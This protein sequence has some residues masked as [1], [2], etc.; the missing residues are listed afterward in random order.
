MAELEQL[1]GY[2]TAATIL[3]WGEPVLSGG[4]PD[5]HRVLL[6]GGVQVM[7]KPGQEEPWASVVRREAAGWQ[8]AKG[9]GFVG[10]VA[11]TGLRE[12][13]MRST[14][15][16]VVSSVQVT[17]PDGHGWCTSVDRLPPQEIWGAAV[18][19]AV[20]AHADHNINNWLGVPAPSD[21]CETHLRL[22]DTGNAFDIA[23]GSINST[24]YEHHHREHLPDELA[25]A[26]QRFVDNVP[27]ELAELLGEAE[28]ECVGHRA[29]QLAES[30]V[31]HIE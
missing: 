15:D 8:V 23:G 3:T 7:A 5:K 20:V 25:E 1:E 6:A 30:G 22:V 12:V 18:F 31:L 9:L 14:G 17:W 19:D 24:F 29:A 16:P 4:H 13:P 2:L 11:A 26:V 21:E 27:S 10:L 28:A